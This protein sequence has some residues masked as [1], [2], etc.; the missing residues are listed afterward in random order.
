MFLDKSSGN[1]FSRKCSSI[2]S[3]SYWKKILETLKT[4]QPVFFLKKVF[5]IFL[6]SRTWVQ[7]ILLYA[8]FY[9]AVTIL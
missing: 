3:T 4:F 8:I 6:G 1:H 7:R 2:S 5:I 9:F